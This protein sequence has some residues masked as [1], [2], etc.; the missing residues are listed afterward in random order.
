M[1]VRI[2]KGTN[3][4]GGCIT[5]IT[6]NQGTRIIID[7]GEDLPDDNA[8]KR[9]KNPKI[10]GL[11]T[12][13]KTYDAVFITHSHGDHIGLIH[14]IL[15]D[16][17]VYVE[18]ISKKIYTLLSV[19]TSKSIR[20]NTL[21]MP[22]NKTI[23]IKDMRITPYFVD[24]SAYHSAMILIEADGKRILHTGDFRNNGLNGKDFKPT[25]KAIGHVDML[26]TEGTS[27]SRPEV[28]NETEEHLMIR[29]KEYFKK[30]DQVFIL[31]SSTNIDRLKGFYQVTKTTGK[32]FIE[33][34]FT[35]NLAVRLKDATIPNPYDNDDVYVWVISKYLRKSLEFKQK[36]VN[37]LR[38]CA[39]QKAYQNKKYCFLIKASMLEAIQKL[40][41]KG[42]ITNACLIYSMWSGY[43]EKEDMQNFLDEIK[44]YGIK[45]IVDLH[46][47]GHADRQTIAL[48]NSLKAQKVIPIHTTKPEEL[49]NVL[50]NVILVKEN[51]DVEVSMDNKEKA[52]HFF[53]YFYNPSKDKNNIC[54]RIRGTKEKPEV[55]VYYKG[56]KLF[57]FYNGA[58]ILNVSLF[59]PNYTNADDLM[60]LA[61]ANK[62]T[63]IKP[64]Q[65][66]NDDYESL[67][68]IGFKLEY[69]S[70]KFKL[71][72]STSEKGVD[73][74]KNAQRIK[75][76]LQAIVPIDDFTEYFPRNKGE[77]KG[78]C[79]TINK[80]ESIDLEKA[81]KLKLLCYTQTGFK[82][83]KENDEYLK[84]KEP[85]GFQSLQVNFRLKETAFDYSTS[86]DTLMDIM[87]RRAEIYA[88]LAGNYDNDFA[89]TRTDS[90]KSFQ[91]TLVSKMATKIG[92]KDMAQ[93][94]L[95]PFTKNDI[96]FEME[97][98]F[99]ASNKDLKKESEQEIDEENNQDETIPENGR[100]RE[101]KKGRIDNIFIDFEH[102]KVK[103]IEL[104][105]DDGV[106]GG[107]NGIH[108]HLLDMANGLDKNHYF[109]NEF[110]EIVKNRYEILK[111]YG[112]KKEYDIDIEDLAQK[113]GSDFAISYDIIC[114]Y[115][116][117]E[118]KNLVTNIF[119]EIKDTNILDKKVF[120]AVS[121]DN[122]KATI[123]SYK[124]FKE[125]LEK[126]NE[127]NPANNYNQEWLDTYTIADYIKYLKEHHNCP[128]NIWVTDN[129]Y[130]RYEKLDI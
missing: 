11:T 94:S 106:I 74:L 97:F 76:N 129:N 125:N 61:C 59:L 121:K 50:D 69:A 75:E 102:K 73:K 1:K 99:Y 19:F 49:V 109:K 119:K 92:R 6:S 89:K 56:V 57:D 87:T 101:N 100:S 72:F 39:K 77:A 14:Y 123:Y 126:I 23:T 111:Y 55:K 51:E 16:I 115:S 91:Q 114:G 78:Y 68:T 13:D 86:F 30:Y 52:T 58:I 84:T 22:F 63:E 117:P 48:L 34:L 116:K 42:Y 113:L 44:K 32:T 93:A 10:D 80:E 79:L 26:I 37:N 9:I 21:D 27:L 81:F 122:K 18:D 67:K 53:N 41:S 65:K 2:L 128:V 71:P 64:Y 90:E 40:A 118:N 130:S 70:N 25:L 88:G 43:K 82:L 33:D 54:L 98:T 15:D 17:P 120:Y 24:H 7:F 28:V 112:I 12:G 95:S 110:A 108:K 47:S 31:Q 105:I 127:K 62:I 45:E 104:K 66:V 35:A 124:K 29:A 4:I 107:T 8:T 46:T 5:E 96:P 103:F 36:Y 3:Q 83:K 20:F 38:R 85:T 60:E